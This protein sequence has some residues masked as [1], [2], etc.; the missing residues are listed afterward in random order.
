MMNKKNSVPKNE[1]NVIDKKETS[2]QSAVVFVNKPINSKS[3]DILGYVAQ[4]DAIKTAINQGA[5]T[6]GVISGY[7]TGKSSLAELLCFEDK[8]FVTPIRINMWDSLE[9]NDTSSGSPAQLMKLTKTFLYQLAKRD[10]R[11]AAYIN[12]RLSK[13]YGFATISTKSREFTKYLVGAALLFVSPQIVKLIIYFAFNLLGIVAGPVMPALHFILDALTVIS[14][15]LAIGCLCL[16]L[17]KDGVVFSLWDSQG[18]RDPELSDTYSIY[19]EIIEYIYNKNTNRHRKK[20]FGKKQKEQEKDKVQIVLIEDLDRVSNSS[21]ELVVGF[22]KEIYKYVNLIPQHM[23]K[24]FAFVIAVMP[25]NELSNAHIG[26]GT[27]KAEDGNNDKNGET[28]VYAKVFDY[29][30]N[31]HPVHMDDYETIVLSLLKLQENGIKS[32]TGIDVQNGFPQ[33]LQWIIRGNNL[34]L[35][36]LKARLNEAFSVYQT[37]RHRSQKI[38]ISMKK[39]AVVAYLEDAYPNEFATLIQQEKSFSEVIREVEKHLYENKLS[40]E[41]IQTEIKP[42]LTHLFGTVGSDPQKTLPKQQNEFVNDIAFMMCEKLIEDDFRQYFYVYPQDGEILTTA[43]KSVRNLLS[44]M[45]VSNEE[46]KEQSENIESVAKTSPDKIEQWIKRS[47]ELGT[48]ITEAILFDET[49]LKISYNSDINATVARIDQSLQWQGHQLNDATD[50]LIFIANSKIDDDTKQRLFQQYADAL[51]KKWTKLSEQDIVEARLT[52]I[53]NVEPFLLSFRKLFVDPTI[54]IITKAE[55]ELVS[56]EKKAV[57]LINTELI[58]ETN[59][60]YLANHFAKKLCLTMESS[61]AIPVSKEVLDTESTIEENS[62]KIL[63]KIDLHVVCFCKYLSGDSS[64]TLC[65]DILK[66]LKE[67]NHANVDVFTAIMSYNNLDVA[68]LSDYLNTMS[69]NVPDSYFE[70]IEKSKLPMKLNDSLLTRLFQNKCYFVYLNNVAISNETNKLPYKELDKNKVQFKKAMERLMNEFPESFITIRNWA[71]A[72][73]GNKLKFVELFKTPFSII[74]PQ[75]LNSISSFPKA[76]EHIDT[77]AITLNSV[78]MISKY[79]NE[80]CNTEDNTINLMNWLEQKLIP[81]QSSICTELF[82]LFDWEKIPLKGLS[83]ENYN[84]FVDTIY[85][86]TS[87]SAPD[88][89]LFF[90]EKTQHICE[91]LEQVLWDNWFSST[92]N[93]RES[94]WR[95]YYLL[96]N[97]SAD[98]NNITIEILNQ[99]Y[100]DTFP[101][102]TIA[103]EFESKELFNSVLAAILKKQKFDFEETQDVWNNEK[104]VEVFNKCENL[105]NIMHKSESFLEYIITENLYEQFTPESLRFLFGLPQP[106]KLVEYILNGLDDEEKYKYLMG[107]SRLCTREDSEAFFELMMQSNNIAISKGEENF[108]YNIMRIMWEVDDE[109]PRNYKAEYKQAFDAQYPKQDITLL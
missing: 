66:Y 48:Y 81:Q 90:M 92:W 46:C 100:I 99:G 31:L 23:Q 6:V 69:D 84:K 94:Q 37:I 109:H 32:L 54:P 9:E 103:K 55:I 71:A 30:V 11:F 78:E 62:R 3:E 1:E 25:E 107:I 10:F 22:L 106:I 63:A 7:G 93:T 5:K 20:W 70:A 43:E 13:N 24:N 85:P 15:Y 36:Q 58:S 89:A 57:E 80:S 60:I 87:L 95:K 59:V 17:I 39:C 97:L 26:S 28:T 82:S 42:R 76:L 12:K 2:C 16:W 77:A 41:D 21:K 38:S 65:N 51:L 50:R 8:Q 4:A 33:E 96:A 67:N 53:K 102:E 47:A 64:S 29:M 45:S 35:R 75:Q 83:Q 61:D 91:A 101:S 49:L 108:A 68:L 73:H 104:Y 79:I 72:K 19:T 98:V 44:K 14:P 34:T 18:K 105:R 27:P 52:L 56:D 74:E 40:H 86:F 88:K